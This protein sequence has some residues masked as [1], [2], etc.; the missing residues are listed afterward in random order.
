MK[1]FK[2]FVA[3]KDAIQEDMTPNPQMQQ[4]MN[5]PANKAKI[6]Q[7]L[8]QMIKAPTPPRM[9]PTQYQS[10]IKNAIGIAKTTNPP[11]TSAAVDMANAQSKVGQ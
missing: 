8:Q 11:T 5:N 1:K 9:N 4:Q 10:T 3:A 2:E 6:M 7:Q